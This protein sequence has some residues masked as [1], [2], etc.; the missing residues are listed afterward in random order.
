MACI[1]LL[2]IEAFSLLSF[3]WESKSFSPAATTMA[4]SMVYRAEMHRQLLEGIDSKRL[5]EGINTNIEI[6]GV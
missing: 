3:H 5:L 2:F 1:T 4:S 6:R